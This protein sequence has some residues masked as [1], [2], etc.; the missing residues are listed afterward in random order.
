[1]KHTLRL[2]RT[3]L[4]RKKPKTWLI[5]CKKMIKYHVMMELKS[6]LNSCRWRY[7]ELKLKSEKPKNTILMLFDKIK[8]LFDIY[9]ELI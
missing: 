7:I 8:I 5:F 3:W 1:M 9:N 6:I 2:S 4:N